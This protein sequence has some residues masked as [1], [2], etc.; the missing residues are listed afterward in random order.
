MLY[1]LCA[2]AC[3]LFQDEAFALWSEKWSSLYEQGSRSWKV[4]EDIASN[5]YLINL[6]DNDFPR[7]SIL[8]AVL[9]DMLAVANPV[10][11]GNHSNCSNHYLNSS[12]VEP[13]SNAV[14]G[15]S[16]SLTPVSA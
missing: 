4:I 11:N 6:V 8:W 13:R 14:N 16:D 2:T 1:T 3:V 10:Q 7:E 5:Y 12:K 15:H 9:D